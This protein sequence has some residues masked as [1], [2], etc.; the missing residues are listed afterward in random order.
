MDMLKDY[1]QA[2]MCVS[3]TAEIGENGDFTIRFPVPSFA[4]QKCFLPPHTALSALSGRHGK[5]FHGNAVIMRASALKEA[6]GFPR[7]LGYFAD[8]F[9]YQVIAAKFGIC[10]IP[11]ALSARRI[12]TM[13][14]SATM[15]KDV[16]KQLAITHHAKELM[17]SRHRDLFSSAYITDWD[18]SRRLGLALDNFHSFRIIQEGFL[19]R[20]KKIQP[21][22]DFKSRFLHFLVGLMLR[23]QYLVTRLCIS[24]C[25]LGS[26]LPRKV[27]EAARRR[28]GY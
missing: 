5:W 9:I 10:F 14:Y 11:E 23:A 3:L 4:N 19:D 17:L 26:L 12:L 8:G 25:V 1:P 18:R 28:L 2:G 15:E 27:F 13:S 21:C 24:C 20:L 16:D 22:S 6:G 7:E